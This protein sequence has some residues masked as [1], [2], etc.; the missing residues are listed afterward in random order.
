MRR[1]FPG[2]LSLFLALNGFAGNPAPARA[3]T[4]YKVMTGVIDKYPVSMYLFCLDGGV[5]GYY[6]YESS[7]VPIPVSG[8]WA[9]GNLHLWAPGDRRGQEFFVGALT[10]S[11]YTGS[12]SIGAQSFPFQLRTIPR[13][14]GY[15]PFDYVW[16][17]GAQKRPK[18]NQ[19]VTIDDGPTY[20]VSTVW[21]SDSAAVSGLLKQDIFRLLDLPLQKGTTAGQALIKSRNIFLTN[22]SRDVSE[23]QPSYEYK[24]TLNVLYQTSR[25]LSLNM[26]EY[27][28]TG[29][30]HGNTREVYYCYD[31]QS[32][33]RLN[34]GDVIDT[35]HYSRAMSALLEQQYRTNNQIPADTRLGESLSQDTIPL[36][37]NFYLTGK[38]I[39]FEYN[40]YEIAPYV[41]GGI[42]FFFPYSQ[43]MPFLQPSF[44]R[45]MDL[46]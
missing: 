20:E 23:N 18:R 42:S 19:D 43:V 10:D 37:G 44:K 8:E 36:N 21:P 16:V 32:G 15:V 45:L 38:G 39:G 13:D 25:V 4:W 46:E 11:S 41:L 9:A 40:P 12:W 26:T 1:I 6:Y 2:L 7:G 22:S 27:S 33:R 17:K 35:L 31:L 5:S 30:A 34:I 29:G 28:F 3:I 14:S 24:A